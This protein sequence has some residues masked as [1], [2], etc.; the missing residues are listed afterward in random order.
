MTAMAIYSNHLRPLR[1]EA[2]TI[3]TGIFRNSKRDL[4]TAVLPG[5]LEYEERH[6]LGL[7]TMSKQFA[8]VREV[9]GCSA[10]KGDASVGGGTG[11]RR[12]TKHSTDL[13]ALA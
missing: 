1:A 2:L 3:T 6:M 10:L 11:K 9:V 7:R 8:L 4:W 5:A 12:R 13:E